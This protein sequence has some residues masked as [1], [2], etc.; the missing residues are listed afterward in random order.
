MKTKML[1]SINKLWF[2]IIQIIVAMGYGLSIYYQ[3]SNAD[4]RMNGYIISLIIN[5]ICCFVG[6]IV[7]YKIFDNR[8]DKENWFFVCLYTILFAIDTCLNDS[9]VGL[10]F[11][12]VLLVFLITELYKGFGYHLTVKIFLVFVIGMETVSIIGL[13]GFAKSDSIM[14]QS[15]QNLWIDIVLIATIVILIITEKS[16]FESDTIK[17]TKHQIIPIVCIFVDV[18]CVIGLL[19]AL[20]HRITS[21]AVVADDVKNESTVYIETASEIG[22]TIDLENNSLLVNQL[23]NSRTQKFT[24][25]KAEENGYW[26]IRTSDKNVFDVMNVIFEE[27]NSVISW[28]ENGVEGQL[29]SVVDKGTNLVSFVSYDEN[30]LLTW[31]DEKGVY[32]TKNGVDDHT[33]FFLKNAKTV[34][35]P[36]IGWMV[37]SNRP[38]VIAIYLIIMFA[39]TIISILVIGRLS[40]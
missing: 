32:L 22:K 9:L 7:L 30:Y 5:I 27:G 17:H 12:G 37:N 31:D 29:W 1:E 23:S 25:E 11:I 38:I 16:D 14:L 3:T 2:V 21:F 36:M 4:F 39:I 6:S 28:E 20:Y 15:I 18:I 34:T 19:L 33:L 40:K 8:N 10:V 35:T 24:F 26:H 13:T